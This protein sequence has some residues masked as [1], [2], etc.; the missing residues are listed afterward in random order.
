[1]MD[2]II[3]LIAIYIIIQLPMACGI[4]YLLRKRRRGY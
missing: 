3:L 4:G 1:M 2:I